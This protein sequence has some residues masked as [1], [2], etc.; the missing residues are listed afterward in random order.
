[1]SSK[2]LRWWPALAIVPGVLVAVPLTAASWVNVTGN[3]ANMASQCGN[4][5]MVSAVPNSNT[6]IAGVAGNGLW[7]NTTGSTWSHLGTGA[8]SDVISNRPSWIVYDPAHPGVFWESG[9]YGGTFGVYQTT[10]SGNTFHHLGSAFHNDF[11]SVDFAD[12]NRQTL[13]AGGHEAAQTVYRSTD[14]GQN[15]INIG[16][17]LPANTDWSSDPLLIDAQTYVVN[18]SG[19]SPGT[20]VGIYRTTNGG[21]NWQPVS[22]MGPAGPPLVASNGAIYWPNADG[23]AKS[24]DSGSSWT[25]VGSGLQT[26][27][28]VRPVELPGGKLVAVGASTLVISADG[29]VT[30]A[31]LGPNLPFAPA[32]LT[33]SLDRG[34]FFISHFDCNTVVLP[35]AIMKFDY[36]EPS[37]TLQPVNQTVKQGLNPQFTVGASGTSAFSFQWQVSTNGGSVWTN[38]SN[39]P[40]YSGATSTTLTIAGATT[41]LSG[42]QYRAVATNADGMA[43]SRAATLTVKL[44]IAPAD[45]DGDG[46]SDATIFRP[47]NGAWF[48]LKS[49]TGFT[50]YSAYQWGVST[51]VPVPGDYDGDGM[52]DLAIYRPSNGYWFIALSST[53]YATFVDYQF[54]VSTDLPVTSDYDGD[55]RADL[56]LYRPSTGAWYVAYSSTNF[57]TSSNYVFGVST[58]VPVPG[59]YDGDGKADL[60]LY[61]PSTG[62]WYVAYSSTN[63]TTSAAYA[64]GTSTDK[65]VPADYDG[66][67]KF[68]LALYRPST[69]TWFVAFSS[70]SFATSA[71]YQ[72]GVAGDLP[73]PG[74]FDGDGKM[75]LAIFRPST[76]SWFVLKS[77][78]NFSTYIAFNWGISSD[79][80]ITMR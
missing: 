29:G 16:A 76:G 37:I 40:P 9:I 61:R 57:A 56:A 20:T 38:L 36:A 10:D 71:S 44:T 22:T 28:P 48:T 4:L 42:N 73:V 34:A 51:D 2:L 67:G 6:V 11:V 68:D 69:G 30:W 58:D 60:A 65:P 33:Y 39:T 72:W 17:N 64:F 54:G 77:S 1:M 25:Q 75:D 43:T 52:I 70:T 21:M 55:G 45:F 27:P 19:N 78:T 66:D 47:S 15:W 12:P 24:A 79:V 49:S 74:D 80:P 18:L 41:P 3:L 63:F 8:G 50:G 14:G 53:N 23:L 32:S 7:T 31:P 26:V 46:K 13:V 62:N 5:T 59:D 35:D